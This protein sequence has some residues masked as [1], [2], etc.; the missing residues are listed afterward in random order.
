[1]LHDILELVPHQVVEPEE[2]LPDLLAQVRHFLHEE[3]EFTLRRDVH[4]AG[5]HKLVPGLPAEHRNRPNNADEV[6]LLRPVAQELD[7]TLVN[8][9]FRFPVHCYLA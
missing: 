9:P 3:D 6:I 8:L 5:F 4:P 1:M 7:P 2:T